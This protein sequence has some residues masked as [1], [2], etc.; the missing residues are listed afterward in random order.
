MVTIV[1]LDQHTGS[2][3]VDACPVC[4]QTVQEY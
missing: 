3:I 1:D 2:K 4:G